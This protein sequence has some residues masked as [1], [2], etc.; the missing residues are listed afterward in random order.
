[1]GWSKTWAQ[2]H[3]PLFSFGEITG[4]LRKLPYCTALANMV[5]DLFTSMNHHHRDTY[6]V[7]YYTSWVDGSEIPN[8]HLEYI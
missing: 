2:D 6:T 1:M 5:E 7:V 4:Y 8:N 3:F